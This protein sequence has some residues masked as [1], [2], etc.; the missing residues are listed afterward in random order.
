L[1]L[2]DVICIDARHAKAALKMQ[3][4]KGG[5]NDAAGIARCADKSTRPSIHKVHIPSQ[6]NSSIWDKIKNVRL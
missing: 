6:R 2:H 4:N 3:I 1:Q 5:R